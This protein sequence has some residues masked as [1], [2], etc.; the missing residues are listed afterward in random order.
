MSDSSF[1]D[2]FDPFEYLTARAERQDDLSKV[3]EEEE[4]E[5]NEEGDPFEEDAKGNNGSFYAATPNRRV[6]DESWNDFVLVLVLVLVIIFIGGNGAFVLIIFIGE[7]GDLECV[8]L[9][10]IH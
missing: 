7:N 6:S 2:S 8:F 5:V 4:E 1:Y 3:D 10:L 9:V